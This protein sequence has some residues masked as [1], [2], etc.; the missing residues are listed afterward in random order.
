MSPEMDLDRVARDIQDQILADARKV[1]SE[2]VIELFLDPINVGELEDPDGQATFTGPC[3][4]TM[5]IFLGVRDG[6]IREATFLTDGC[7]PSLACGCVVT[8]IARGKTGEEAARIMPEDILEIL[9]G[10]PESYAHC[11]ELAVA[12]LRRAIDDIHSKGGN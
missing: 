6:R 5:S 10:L 4:D 3:G 2:R 9:G 12:T 8:D 11:A 7:G 1:F